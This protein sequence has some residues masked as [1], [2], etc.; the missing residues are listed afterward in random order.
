MSYYNILYSLVNGNLEII[1]SF[2]SL[3]W[4]IYEIIRGIWAQNLSYIVFIER[5]CCNMALSMVWTAMAAVSFIY[6]I[7]AGTAAQVSA[8]F[9]EGAQEAVTTAVAMTGPV[10]SL[11]HI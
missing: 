11:I 6:S 9:S 8:S 10:L 4:N 3:I 1:L 2:Q 5:T 7:F